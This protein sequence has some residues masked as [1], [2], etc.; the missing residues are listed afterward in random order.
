MFAK[1]PPNGYHAGMTTH[2]STFEDLA[3]EMIACIFAN[4]MPSLQQCLAHPNGPQATLW[5]DSGP[6]RTAIRKQHN[7]FLPVLL[8]YTCE[9]HA[10]FALS[11]CLAEGEIAAFDTVLDYNSAFA[12]HLEDNALKWV[13]GHYMRALEDTSEDK[14]NR[15]N[16]YTE[17]LNRFFERIPYDV[18]EWQLGMMANCAHESPEQTQSF[19]LI[20]HLWSERNKNVLNTALDMTNPAHS[21]ARKI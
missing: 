20:E 15:I 17:I 6:L 10:G 8:P 2:L 12:R 4:D 19:A 14:H 3:L 5:E 16:T 1:Y 21:L 9:D 11:L 18:V 13:G 7:H